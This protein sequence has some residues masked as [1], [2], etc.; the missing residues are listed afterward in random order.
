MGDLQ[1]QFIS[2]FIATFIPLMFVALML[3]KGE[4]RQIILFFGWGLFSGVLA[5]HLNNSFGAGQ[6]ER[7]ALSIAPMIEEICKGL[8]L[9]LFLNQKKYPSVSKLIIFC[10]MASGVG[11]SIQE[12]IYFFSLSSR[13]IN[14]L[15]VLVFR[16]LTTALMHGMVTAAFGIGLMM[17]QQL[18]NVRLPIIFGLLAFCASLHALFNLLLQTNFAAIAVVMPVAMF[19]AV[20]VFLGT[21]VSLDS[22]YTK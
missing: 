4:S 2:V 1:F 9:L 16:T 6:T 22:D 13:E 14:D 8:P 15:L 5:F 20:W 11:F 10:A 21:L 7:L 12:S 17:T 18:K 19:A 3:G